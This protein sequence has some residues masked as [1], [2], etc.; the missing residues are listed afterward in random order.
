M[1]SRRRGQRRFWV[2][3][4]ARYSAYYWPDCI[5]VKCQHC[6]A[7]A[8]F[9]P[10][11][12][13]WRIRNGASNSPTNLPV[14]GEKAGTGSCLACGRIFNTINWPLDAFYC[15]SVHGGEYWAWNEGY[16]SA[17]RARVAGDRVHERQLCLENWH[18]NYFLT[19]LPK[20]LVLKRHRP[21]ILRTIDRWLA[22]AGAKNSGYGKQSKPQQCVARAPTPVT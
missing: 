21:T 10:A 22:E 14:G 1:E 9:K 2:T 15:A 4:D 5:A 12:T 7:K 17:L 11:I 19:R 16:L 13:N 6:G 18:Y 3:L 8:H 20:Y